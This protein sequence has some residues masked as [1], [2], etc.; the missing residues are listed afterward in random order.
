MVKQ[1]VK[2]VV[3]PVSETAFATMLSDA[4]IGKL[5]GAQERKIMT[6]YDVKKSGESI[7]A[8]HLRP[9]PFRKEHGQKV[10][11]SFLQSRGGM[12][13][14]EHDLMFF[15]DAGKHGSL[16]CATQGY[17]RGG[18]VRCVGSISSFGHHYW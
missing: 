6:L 17:M 18:Y 15:F 8:P 13:L 7:T 9:A 14:H 2:L 5:R 3:E 16:T 11:R 12:E 10:V 1:R 4:E